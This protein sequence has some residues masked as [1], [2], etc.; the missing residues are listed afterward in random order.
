MSLFP[1][2]ATGEFTPLFRLLDEYD[3]HRGA[4]RGADSIRTFQPRFDV[5]ENDKAY[6][7]HG[8]LPGINQSDINIEFSDPQTIVIS[9][10]SERTFES[11]T[12]PAGAIDGGHEKGHIT[13]K[14]HEKDQAAKHDKIERKTQHGSKYWVSERSVG[15]YHRSFSF[16]ARV[17][18]DAVKASLKNG[19]LSVVVPK[20]APAPL[21][22]ISV[23]EE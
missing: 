19:I 1:R 5:C 4:P 21:K 9:G 12:P 20:A 15:E 8:E 3:T 16:P 18:Q 17:D 22:K 10:R 6:E 2:F 13:E 11:G 14:G 7:L 23:A